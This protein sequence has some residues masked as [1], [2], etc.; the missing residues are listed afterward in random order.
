MQLAPILAFLLSFALFFQ[1]HGE[2]EFSR[3]K[4]EQYAGEFWSECIAIPGLALKADI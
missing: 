3:S 1:V 4:L 2:T